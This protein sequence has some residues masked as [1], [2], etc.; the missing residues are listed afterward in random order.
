MLG[1]T[2]YRQKP[3]LN[4]I[5][6]FYCHPL[7]LV[8]EI[9]GDSHIG[10]E[11]KDRIRQERLEEQGLIFLRF[12]DLLVKQNLNSVLIELENWI[13]TQENIK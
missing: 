12:D 9:D 2:F 4:Y 6:D 5:V 13:K 10:M 1:Y 11:I 3:L 7:N 8:I